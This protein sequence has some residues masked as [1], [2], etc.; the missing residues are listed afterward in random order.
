MNIE[1]TTCPHCGKP[2]GSRISAAELK[3]TVQVMRDGGVT[4]LASFDTRIVLSMNAPEGGFHGGF[5]PPVVDPPAASGS[6]DPL[7]PVEA[8]RGHEDLSA[9]RPANY[10]PVDPDALSPED[11]ELLYASARSV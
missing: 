5:V 9:K 7:R 1:P 3:D 6:S 2:V 11:E 8:S 4:D 10:G